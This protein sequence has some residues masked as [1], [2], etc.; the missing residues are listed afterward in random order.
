MEG[1]RALDI[2]A[3]KGFRALKG[4]N[5]PLSVIA[6]LLVEPIVAPIKEEYLGLIIIRILYYYNSLVYLSIILL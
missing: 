3:L 6:F 5:R 2:E 1:F 4:F